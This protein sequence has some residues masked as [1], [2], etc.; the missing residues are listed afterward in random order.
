M[1]DTLSQLL[2]DIHLS[3]GEFRYVQAA[4][5]WGFA[6]RARG[7]ASFH[8][9]IAG[10]AELRVAGEP[11]QILEAGDM[12]VM[13]SGRDHT[14]QDPDGAPPEG[15]WPDLSG[16][17]Q[18]HSQEP[19]TLGGAGEPAA[20]LSAR[21]QFDA[22]LARPLLSAL[23]PILPIRSIS[24]QPPEWLRIGLEFLA[25][26]G[27]GKPGRQAIVNRLAGILFIECVR[28]HVAALPEGASNWLRALRD[29]A[30]SAVLSALHQRPGH[31]WTV[32][33][34][35]GI[36]CLS[37]S[38]FA[39]RFTQILGQPPL[40]YLAEHRMRLA[41]WQLQHTQQPVRHIAEVVGYASETAFSQAFKRQYGCAPSRFR[42]QA[43]AA[44]HA[45]EAATAGSAA[46][47]SPTPM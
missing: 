7:L 4:R 22:D 30:L 8:L 16:M 41:A 6:F 9:V 34:L 46:N 32:P 38:A 13:T 24:R 29:P 43:S 11:P 2:D 33:E 21:F 26:E 12:A 5:P 35:A 23:P 40:S 17:I 27:V 31:G 36:A 37:R 47:A 19:V 45:A 15:E 18:G 10:R 44:G 25:N 3:G 28:A 14:M 42:Q 1:D 20:L 39:D